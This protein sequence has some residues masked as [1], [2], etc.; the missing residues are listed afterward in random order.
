M[1]AVSGNIRRDVFG[2]IVIDECESDSQHLTRPLKPT[3]TERQLCRHLIEE[4]FQDLVG[5]KGTLVLNITFKEDPA[6]ANLVDVVVAAAE[7]AN[8]KT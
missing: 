4:A 8:G 3:E 1:Y 7:A 2:R 5:K 6:P